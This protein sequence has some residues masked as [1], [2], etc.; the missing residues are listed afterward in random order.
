MV[1]ASMRSAESEPGEAEV[2]RYDCVVRSCMRGRDQRKAKRKEIVPRIRIAANVRSRTF[3]V[4][5]GE[6]G[7]MGNTEFNKNVGMRNAMSVIR[8]TNP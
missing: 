4:S 1:M 6:S 5:R 2:L 8:T 3:G 7:N